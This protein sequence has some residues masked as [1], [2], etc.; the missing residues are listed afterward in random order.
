MLSRSL[1]RLGPAALLALVAAAAVAQP[2]R[3]TEDLEVRVEDARGKALAGAEVVLEYVSP[4]LGG[5]APLVTDE[6][7]R[8]ALGGLTPGRWA[9]EVRKPGFMSFRAEI[10]LS[11]GEKPEIVAAS[12]HNVPGAVS[13]LRVRLARARNAPP[14]P[15]RVERA[16]APWVAPPPPPAAPVL[17]PAAAPVAAAA[18]P[19]VAP[20][21]A[22][23][24][25]SPAVAAPAEST[26]AA[27]TRVVGPSIPA[28]S[29]AL[30]PAVPVAAAP[31]VAPSPGSEPSPANSALTPAPPA[32]PAPAPVAVV[33]P[34]AAAP[35]PPR[36][37]AAAPIARAC[38]ECRP[39]ESALLAEAELAAGGGSCPGDLAAGLATISR[40]ELAALAAALPAGCVVLTVELPANARYSGFR[41]EAAGPNGRGEDCLAGRSCPAGEC[42]F[43][44][45]PIVR[46]DGDATLVLALFESAAARRAGFTVYWRRTR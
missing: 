25:P 34:P 21:P 38:Y 1:L 15:A 14:A 40:A 19:A 24:A 45:E 32:Q 26:P 13:T 2:W 3:G 41:Y 9:L 22:A 28:S 39:G 18:P 5:P 11:G 33:A 23:P 17:A 30:A 10:A 7:G 31:P 6:R 44:A 8:V 12:Q 46:R 42:R 20:A 16:A 36:L 27:P 37:V 43:P 29:P 35:A 4:A